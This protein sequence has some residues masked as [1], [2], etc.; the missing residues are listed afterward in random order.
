MCGYIKTPQFAV[1]PGY[2]SNP[3]WLS[4]GNAAGMCCADEDKSPISSFGA[5]LPFFLH[6]V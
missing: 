5:S 2:H 1:A 4:A 6:R 3:R